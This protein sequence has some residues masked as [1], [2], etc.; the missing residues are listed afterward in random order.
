M[1][2][3]ILSK[4]QYNDLVNRIDEIKSAIDLKQKQ[5]SE[6]FLDNQQFIDTMKVS[7]RLAQS[8]RDEGVISFSKIGNK[9]YYKLSDVEALMQ[10]N[11]NK[12]FKK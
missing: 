9:I 2:A 11:Y 3:V 1:E 8:W 4:D 10:K 5:P 12:A 6:Q 7:K